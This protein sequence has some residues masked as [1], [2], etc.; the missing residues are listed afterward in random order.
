MEGEITI[1]LAFK[2]KNKLKVEHTPLGDEF[3]SLPWSV[4]QRVEG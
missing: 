2:H 3:Y 1:Q 4:G